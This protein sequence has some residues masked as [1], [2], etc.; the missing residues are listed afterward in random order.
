MLQFQCSENAGETAQGGTGPTKVRLAGYI[1]E[2][3]KAKS[4][5]D[6]LASEIKN[7]VASYVKSGFAVEPG[8]REQVLLLAALYPKPLRDAGNK[9]GIWSP[10]RIFY[11]YYSPNA[12]AERA[13]K[14]FKPYKNSKKYHFRVGMNTIAAKA[15]E[16][17]LTVREGFCACSSC[18]APKFDFKNCM[19]TTM[20]GRAQSVTCPPLRPVTGVVTR[21]AEI[22]EFAKE[23][24]AGQVRAV[25]VVPD[26]M[27]LEGAPF[28]LCLLVGDAFQA[29]EPVVFGGEYFE[30]GFYLV[31]MKW[32]E[33]VRNDSSGQRCYRLLA[34]ERM[35]SVHSLIRCEV[36]KLPAVDPIRAH[37]PQLFTL[38]TDQCGFIIA[39]AEMD[40]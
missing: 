34:D 27:A 25:D 30:E 11:A 37:V 2:R 40:F 17:K 18:H 8:T 19:F 7:K 16:G 36:K 38:T 32:Y 15:S 20:L 29:S 9:T 33:F 1:E 28:W 13:K 24:K 5:G 4:V 14:N 10:G 21:T 23:L 35:L 31:K 26:Q 3:G 39:H 12:L 6:G 22:A